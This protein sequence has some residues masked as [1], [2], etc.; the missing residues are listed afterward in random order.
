MSKI[1]VY[2]LAQKMGIDNKELIARLKSVGVEVKNHMAVID[3]ADANALTVP[4]PVK[5]V[6]K[7]EV[8]VTT[9][10]IR[11]RA[12]AVEAVP[13]E[14]PPA[15][16]EA[17]PVAEAAAPAEVSVAEAAEVEAAVAQAAPSEEAHPAA[18]QAERPK[19]LREYEPEK[20]TATRARILGRIEIPGQKP[21][22]RQPER[23]EAQRP[24]PGQPV[25]GARPAPGQRPAPAGA[26]TRAPS[27]PGERPTSPTMVEVPV[28]V[29][30]RK[31]GRKGKEAPAA[32]GGKKAAPGAKKKEAFK[33]GEM[34]EKRER[35]F[36]PGPRPGKGKRRE[37]SAP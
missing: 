26:P 15:P 8:R 35:I 10:V 19:T 27:R 18:P 20:A 28:P 22:E 6:A 3:E 25:P 14:A 7:E 29:D 4:P 12:K 1:R 33:K 21:Q 32:E 13:E 23:R 24:A 2:E 37:K 17:P 31:K 11:R 34:L 16:V 5:D 36:E 30:E 9:T